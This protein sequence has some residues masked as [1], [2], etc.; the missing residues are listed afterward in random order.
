LRGYRPGGKIPATAAVWW[1]WSRGLRPGEKE[2]DVEDEARRQKDEQDDVEAHRR[3]GQT[4]DADDARREGD[5]EP[6]VEAHRRVGRSELGR[7]EIGRSE[8]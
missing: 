8:L 3:V 2:D 5:D 1:S 4:E 7:S 6:D